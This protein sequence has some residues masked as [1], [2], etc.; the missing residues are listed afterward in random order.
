MAAGPA[1]PPR[2]A[3]GQIEYT[4]I[5]AA[6]LLDIGERPDLK[7]DELN[8]EQ[9]VRYNRGWRL[10]LR[11]TATR[12]FVGEKVLAP[13]LIA[14][15]VV[16]FTTYTPDPNA[17]PADPGTGRSRLYAIQL[18]DATPIDQGGETGQQ[19]VSID[20]R[21]EDLPG[22]GLPAGPGVIFPPFDGAAPMVLV[23]TNMTGVTLK[24]TMLRTYWLQDHVH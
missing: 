5:D 4:K 7:R 12:S 24:H 14:D 3:A 9:T 10:P 19:K 6:A 22:G 23:G 13:A 17:S 8:A 18:E 11:D 20:D 21:F 2:N 16:L 15:G 1:G